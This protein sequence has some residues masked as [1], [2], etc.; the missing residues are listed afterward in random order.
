MG[1]IDAW[2]ALAQDLLPAGVRL[3]PVRGERAEAMR[4]TLAPAWVEAPSVDLWREAFAAMRACPKVVA[5]IPLLSLSRLAQNPKGKQN[6]FVS[7][8]LDGADYQAWEAALVEA[9]TPTPPTP[10]PAS[11]SST[12][13]TATPSNPTPSIPPATATPSNSPT[14]PLALPITPPAYTPPTPEQLAVWGAWAAAWGEGAAALEAREG[15]A[16]QRWLDE[17]ESLEMVCDLAQ[18]A[19]SQKRPLKEVNTVLQRRAVKR[20]G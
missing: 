10:S 1:V 7:Q 13:A 6:T 3:K 15:R 12:T 16:L 8:W 5:R 19:G 14:H 20:A 9:D 17:G 11:T 18:R 2:N 4:A